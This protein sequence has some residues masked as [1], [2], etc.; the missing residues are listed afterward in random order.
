MINKSEAV[1]FDDFF[2]LHAIAVVCNVILESSKN[3]KQKKTIQMAKM[4]KC[5]CLV[6]WHMLFEMFNDF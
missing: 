3:K 1:I 6:S 2:F 5:H 4:P